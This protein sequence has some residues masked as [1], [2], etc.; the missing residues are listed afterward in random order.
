MEDM[1]KIQLNSSFNKLFSVMPHDIF[2]ESER[3]LL[4]GA[5]FIMISKPVYDKMIS[6]KEAKEEEDRIM[7]KTANLNCKGI[8]YEKNRHIDDAIRVYEENIELGYPATHSFERLMIIYRKKLDYENEIRIIK[9]AIE[10]FSNENIKRY[11]RAL[12][13]ETDNEIIERL[14]VGF[15]KCENVQGKERW[16]IYSPYPIMKYQKRLEKAIQLYMYTK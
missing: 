1:V 15:E 8:D 12:I 14:N 5:K 9:I 6:D 2:N 13:N 10:I 11:Q 3:L 4:K 16:Y 7:S